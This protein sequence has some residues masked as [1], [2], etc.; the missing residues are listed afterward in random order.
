[1]DG[2][3]K[4]D[5]E[6]GGGMTWTRTTSAGPSWHIRKVPG[7]IW[8]VFCPAVG[9]YRPKKAIKLSDGVALSH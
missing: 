5:P 4:T 7:R 8:E 2:V 9:H 3:A 6:S 1:M